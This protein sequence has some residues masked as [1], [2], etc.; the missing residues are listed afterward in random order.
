MW[1]GN[2]PLGQRHEVARHP[3]DGLDVEEV[4]VVLER[5]RQAVRRF[6]EG[7]HE[8]EHGGLGREVARVRI[9]REIARIPVRRV[10]QMKQYLE[11][12][13]AARIAR[14][15]QFLH[16]QRERHFLV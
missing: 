15:P 16:E 1:F 2:D 3:L 7:Q 11:Q 12:R 13:I 5:T 8:V 4:D 10:E 6:D 9:G 14:R